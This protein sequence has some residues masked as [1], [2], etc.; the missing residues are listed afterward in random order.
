MYCPNKSSKEYQ[1]L[2]AEFGEIHAYNAWFVKNKALLNSFETE[3]SIPSVEEAKEILKQPV[4]S[5]SDPIKLTHEEE[6]AELQKTEKIGIAMARNLVYTSVKRINNKFK[7]LFAH[8]HYLP[9]DEMSVAITRKNPPFQV[10]DSVIDKIRAKFP[11]IKCKTV[12]VDEAVE[13][14]GA[15][16]IKAN[17][18]ILGNTVHIIAGRVTN[19]TL[20]E[21]FLH[22]FI[23]H[24]Y[25]HNRALYDSL[26][27]EAMQDET[28]KKSVLSR[29]KDFSVETKKKEM[30]TQK[31]AELLNIEFGK[32]ENTRED[33]LKLLDKLK[34]KLAGFFTKLF[35][36]H[37]KVLG[38]RLNFNEVSP[39]ISLGA[40]AQII[41]T[42]GIILPVET[43]FH[44]T[45]SLIDEI[46]D[47]SDKGGYRVVDDKYQDKAG[48]TFNRLTEWV[49]NSFS[50]HAG[51]TTED[52]AKN[53]AEFEFKNLNP[54]DVG[55]VL[56]VKLPDGRYLSLD[57]L[58]Q[59]KVVDFNTAR[60]YGT[61]A[62]L[63]IEK[64]I[65]TKLGLDTTDLKIKIDKLSEGN[66][67]QGSINLD[68]LD[69]I[70]KNIDRILAISGINVTDDR[71]SADQKDKVL[72]EL[73]YVVEQLGIGT[74]IDGLIEHPDG[75]LSI[76]DWKTGRLMN[77][78]MTTTFIKFGDQIVDIRD[79]KLDRAKLEVVLRAL[80]VKYKNPEAKFRQL[81]I[82]YLNK[83]TLVET[84][85]IHLSSYL[86]ALKDYFKAEN[87]DLYKELNDKKLFDVK[88]Y[89][90]KIISNEKQAEE[91]TEE[92]QSLDEQIVILTNQISQEKN[93]SRKANL[94]GKLI[95]L[96]QERI[97]KE[98]DIPISLVGQDTQISWFKKTFGKLSTASNPIFQT[99]N[100]LIVKAKMLMKSEE[101]EMFSEF[102]A[103][104][105][106]LMDAHGT[107]IGNLGLKYKTTN[108]SG[109]YD[110][111]WVEKDKGSNKGYYRITEEEAEDPA[112]GLTDIQKRYVKFFSEK[113]STLY[114]EVA[115]QP[116]Y[117]DVFGRK[118]TNA[119][120]NNQPLTLPD[121][122]MPRVFMT[123]SDFVEQN[124]LTGTAA[125]W[126]YAQYRAQFMRSNFYANN[127]NDVL[128]FKYMGSDATIGS[129]LHSFNAEE[130]FKQFAKNLLR[131]KHLDPIQSLGVG[132]AQNFAELGRMRDYEFMSDRIMTDITAMKKRTDF[133]AKGLRKISN[134]KI[135]EISVDA[136]F[137]FLKGFVTAGT[138]WL[139]P[140]A[141]L[142]NG[143]YT[144][145]TNHKHGVIGS[146]AK[147]LGV[148]E[149]DLNFT[150]S[151]LLQGDALWLGYKKDAIAGNVENNKLHLLLKKYNYLP[152]AFDYRVRKGDIK[153]ERNKMLDSDNLYF[154]HS[155][156]EDWGGGAIFAA[157]LVHN[158]NQKD[159]KSLYDSYDVKDGKLTWEGG[160]RGK[161]TDGSLITDITY[162]ELNKFKYASA[163]L[164]GNYRDEEK[165]AIELYSYGRM[166]MQFKRF[167]PQQLM[168]LAQTKHESEALGK[169]VEISKDKDGMSIYSWAPEV[170]EGR[171]WLMF[172]HFTNLTGIASNRYDWASLSG[173]QKEA[174][175]TSYVLFLISTLGYML[176]AAAFDDD[177]EDKWLAMSSLKIIKDL[178][179]GMNPVDLIENFQYSSVSAAKLLK[180]S[181]ALG[182]FSVSV[183][184]GDRTK[185]GNFRG[186]TTLAKLL[187][188]FSTIY[189][190]DKAIGNSKQGNYVGFGI[191]DADEYGWD[192]DNI[193]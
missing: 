92:L 150:E 21:E 37:G 90:L 1:A 29:Y 10:D 170:V 8:V 181:K 96:S 87:P 156:F 176:T 95:E 88:E 149:E 15:N 89:G 123:F 91:R 173:K 44:P 178:S 102:D 128:P 125:K 142:R 34:I 179:E 94:K 117:V 119:Q 110:F 40:L 14:I 189:D 57:E 177:D 7:T 43:L 79:S 61:I 175:I 62:H 85:N 141:G 50:K 69:W 157:L 184:T 185:K 26:E 65:K 144:L 146:I 58:T 190:I 52:F 116:V 70:E 103:L 68:R 75:T 136:L 183:A 67:S 124:G 162:E 27:K 168:N 55:G 5:M 104:Q 188:P 118:Q 82:E 109:L 112:N 166:M 155:V 72:S 23:E 111:M 31:L 46:K 19:E 143:V 145:M 164:H 35:N 161:R 30:V 93:I 98:N 158:K 186:E 77:D 16:A 151:D 41:N 133:M 54:E 4:F 59:E 64:A 169:F 17:S 154:F 193:K 86:S 32:Q 18:F 39:N 25:Q 107:T 63:I 56:K 47:Q 71:F 120:F 114:N 84:Q 36:I 81:S 171:L 38:E 105:K 180:L 80:M 108:N 3:P 121:D 11:T 42:E 172:K 28:L 126:Q 9:N 191:F 73:P 130:A 66:A 174:L 22:P 187:P 127:A 167:V 78:S 97:S 131:K 135:D 137:D 101:D 132:I 74:T 159:G 60:A 122:F 6:L 165:A 12:S 2:V 115:K 99:F 192:L 20:L 153:S 148:D 147:K 106:E 138:M 48:A 152:D 134:D 140:F 83:N 76:K 113:L 24:L 13:L 129:H 139:K 163:L 100:K 160:V 33:L 49:R 182:E 53:S 51:K 45:F